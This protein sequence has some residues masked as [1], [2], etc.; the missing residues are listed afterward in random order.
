[1]TN[2]VPRSHKPERKDDK[3]WTK[4]CVQTMSLTS[5]SVCWVHSNVYC[6]VNIHWIRYLTAVDAILSTTSAVQKYHHLASGSIEIPLVTSAGNSSSIGK[7]P[8]PS[9]IAEIRST[10]T[11]SFVNYTVQ[12]II[13]F[14]NVLQG[15]KTVVLVCCSSEWEP[16]I[17]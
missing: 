17:T 11:I 16:D 3:N 12:G 13:L 10:T 4:Q 6:L 7:N 8:V 14:T 15:H 9:S 2:F 1:M 5:S